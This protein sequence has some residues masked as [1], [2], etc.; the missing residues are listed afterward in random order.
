MSQHYLDKRQDEW[1]EKTFGS[2]QYGDDREE[3][4]EEDEEDDIDYEWDDEIEE[5][6]ETLEN[7]REK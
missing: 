1:I 4:G 6:F 7:E 5:N 2:N 3:Y